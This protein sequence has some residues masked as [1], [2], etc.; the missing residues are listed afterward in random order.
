MIDFLFF[1]K[2]MFSEPIVLSVPPIKPEPSDEPVCNCGLC[3]EIQE[4][5]QCVECRAAR[6]DNEKLMGLN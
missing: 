6:D 3:V 2:E 4:A 1:A 5:C